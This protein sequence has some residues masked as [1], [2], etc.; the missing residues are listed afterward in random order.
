MV[1]TKDD[2]VWWCGVAGYGGVGYWHEIMMVIMHVAG[3]G[4]RTV[5]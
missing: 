2:M 3:P 5:S 4:D 1:T